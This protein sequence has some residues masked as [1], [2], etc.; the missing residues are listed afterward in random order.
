MLTIHEL[1]FVRV[2]HLGVQIV[3]TVMPDFNG[4][5]AVSTIFPSPVPREDFIRILKFLITTVY[6]LK[7]H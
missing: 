7:R 2:D 6:L 3:K 4:Q 5:L 1:K